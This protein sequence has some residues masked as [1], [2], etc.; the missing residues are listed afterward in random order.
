V[1]Y[2]EK[3]LSVRVASKEFSALKILVHCS[4]TVAF[5]VSMGGVE[6]RT[7]LIGHE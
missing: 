4:K 7:V 2:G 6:R 3:L 5:Q 1:E